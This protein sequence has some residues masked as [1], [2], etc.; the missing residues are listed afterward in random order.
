MVPPWPVPLAPPLR[1]VPVPLVRV[2]LPRTVPEPLVR[3]PLPRTAPEPLV[4]VPLPRTVPL[5]LES[6]SCTT[7]PERVDLDAV[8]VRAP[9]D[10]AD[11]RERAVCW[12]FRDG[13]AR[14][15]VE[16]D[17]VARLGEE[18]DGVARLGVERDGVARL[19]VLRDGVA[20]L[21]VLR[22]GVARL[23]VERFGAAFLALL[24]RSTLV[25]PRVVPVRARWANASFAPA[26]IRIVAR[27]RPV[28]SL[29]LG[30]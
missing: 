19:G 5:L 1:T 25:L 3:V 18:R 21:G 15:G 12:V 20:R 26:A 9:R 29:V 6:R 10:E 22:D 16:R 14:L 27:A 8:P 2:P 13:V 28:T 11:C 24:E 4:R 23:G 30:I 17:G 7:P